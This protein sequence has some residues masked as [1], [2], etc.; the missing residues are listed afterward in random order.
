MYQQSNRYR[1]GKNRAKKERD[2][3]KKSEIAGVLSVGI[4]FRATKGEAGRGEP[5]PGPFVSSN[6]L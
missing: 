3:D 1:K 5:N 2:R 4:I 6:G